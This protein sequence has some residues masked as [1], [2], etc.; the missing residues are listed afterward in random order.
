[1]AEPSIE[2]QSSST[3]VRITVRWATPGGFR[4]DWERHLRGG[5]LFLPCEEAL[6]R[7]RALE[8]RLELPSGEAIRCP[9]QV[10][11]P[12]PTGAGLSVRLTREQK[13]RLEMEPG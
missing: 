13:E 2:I 3:P 9:A 4:R 6:P 1:M 11:A 8:L 10:V 12:M 7:N 5:G